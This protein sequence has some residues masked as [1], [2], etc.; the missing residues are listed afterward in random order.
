MFSNSIINAIVDHAEQGSQI[1]VITKHAE[2]IIIQIDNEV[3]VDSITRISRV[4]GQ[5]RIEFING[6]QVTFHRS[7]AWLRGRTANLVVA[8]MGLN[9][10]DLISIIPAAKLGGEIIGYV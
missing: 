9:D 10:D 3:Y 5:E 4:N 1:V 6:A 2:P 7:P 8:P